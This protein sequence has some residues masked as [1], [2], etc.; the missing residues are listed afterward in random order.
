MCRIIYLGGTR[1]PSS[2]HDSHYYVHWNF[3]RQKPI[4][5]TG[6]AH[7]SV[8]CFVRFLVQKSNALI[9]QT[10]VRKQK[11]PI[12]PFQCGRVINVGSM[13]LKKMFVGDAHQMWSNIV[14]GGGGGPRKNE[15]KFVAGL[16][17]KTKY[18]HCIH[19]I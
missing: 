9:N 6:V 16:T 1:K 4:N 11:T 19:T 3:E 2:F 17:D 10:S 15:V 12:A 13:I 7:K 8:F 14:W 18:I 5:F